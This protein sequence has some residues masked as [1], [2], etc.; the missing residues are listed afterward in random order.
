[1]PPHEHL[2]YDGLADHSLHRPLHTE[3]LFIYSL[4]QEHSYLLHLQLGNVTA[5]WTLKPIWDSVL[6]ND[7]FGHFAHY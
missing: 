7:E 2:L 1:M 3:F 4:L 6:D 5:R